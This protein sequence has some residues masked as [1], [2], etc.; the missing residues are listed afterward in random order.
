MRGTS[1]AIV[2]ADHFN[3]MLFAS[4]PSRPE[5]PNI[6]DIRFPRWLQNLFGGVTCVI[7]ILC[8]A[9]ALIL[10]LLSFWHREFKWRSLLALFFICPL[11][12]G[13]STFL[14]RVT[15]RLFARQEQQRGHS[16][17]RALRRTAYAF[18]FLA[19]FIL[20][21]LTRSDAA[22][23]VAALVYIGTSFYLMKLASRREYLEH[24]QSTD[25][26]A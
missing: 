13:A 7:A 26:T 24:N 5:E 2:N 16:S 15:V 10:L 18:L 4:K 17:P 23:I 11:L 6:D 8:G 14:F 9:A 20:I 1:R 3:V 25:P 19:C 22:W 21:C 12:I